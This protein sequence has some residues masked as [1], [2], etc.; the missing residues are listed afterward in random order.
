[1]VTKKDEDLEAYRKSV[2]DIEKQMKIKDEKISE[3]QT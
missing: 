1:V 2:I 3:L